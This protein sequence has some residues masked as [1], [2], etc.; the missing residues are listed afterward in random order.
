M[1]SHPV[2]R[3]G[4]KL[5]EKADKLQHRMSLGPDPSEPAGGYD[6]TPL[7]QAPSGYTVKF[8]FHRGDDLPVADFGSF[9]SDPY[10]YAQL[11]V[12]LPRRHKQDPLVTFRTPTVRK[13]MNPVW[14]CE[15]VV[16]NVP[17]SGFTLK[18]YV[19]DEDPADHDDKLGIA[20][21]EVPR[22]S[23]DWPGFKEKSFKVK[24]RFGSK[25]VYVFTNVSAFATGHHKE[26]FLIM[27]V[28]VL[29]KTAG[30]NGGQ[31]YTVGPLLWLK[32]F[33]P[34]IGRLAGTKDQVQSDDGSGKALSKYK[35]VAPQQSSSLVHA[36]NCR[37]ASKPFK[38]SSWDPSLVNSIIAMSSL[39]HLWQ[40]CSN[41]RASRV[42]FCTRRYTTNTSGSTISIVVLS[43]GP[44]H[45]LVVISL[46]SSSSWPT[47]GRA[48]EFSPMCSRWMA[49][50]GLPKR[51]KSLELTC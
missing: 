36:N 12:D 16:A 3:Y 15:W 23:E 46:G 8:T 5:V 47:M 18:A 11:L 38:F 24:K 7:P 17:A 13:N 1:A 40:A 9:S 19:Y 50:F 26:S 10:V 25:R 34:L 4:P 21:I 44:S 22:L 20:F 43:T 49:S 27:S 29:G 51:A 37:S 35:Y 2:D 31:M 48:V 42:E 41:H 30:D 6:A 33:S 45:T 39:S 32:H 28:E 14:N